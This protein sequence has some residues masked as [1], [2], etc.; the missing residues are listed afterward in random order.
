[1]KTGTLHVPG[2]T[3]YYEVRGFGPVLLMIPPGA[4]DTRAFSGIAKHLDDLYTVV[5]YDRRGLSRST[6]DN[7][8][9]EQRVE[10]H[11]DDAHHLLATL[12]TEPVY[13][14]GSSGGAAVG[15]DLATRYP[16]RVH[17]LVA[18]EPPAVYL[19]P[20]VERSYENIQEIYRSEGAASA[21]QKFVTNVRADFD[22]QELN[23]DLPD[24][25]TRNTHNM[26]FFFE[27]E[28]AMY[29]RYRFDFAALLRAST[30]IVIAGGRTG[31][32]YGG[33]RSATAVANRLGAT[34]MEF[35]GDHAGFVSHPEAFAKQLHD[36]LSDESGM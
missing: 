3:L 28:L 6:L 22:D 2:A 1:M 8:E 13:V 32:A 16:E 35:P 21:F 31:Q 14:F 5:T 20:E 23:V 7:V 10:T 11:S 9:E 15:L 30:R 18:H 19:L 36:V 27:R 25:R 29:G 17:M 34:V 12:T 24:M 4:S 26:M 33:Y